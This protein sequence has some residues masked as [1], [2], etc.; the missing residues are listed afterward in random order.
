MKMSIFLTSLGS[1]KSSG[2]K[3]CGSSALEGT[4][5]ATWQLSCDTSNLSLRRMPLRLANRRS[6]LVLTPTPSGVTAPM[7]VTTMGS[8][9][10]RVMLASLL[11]VFASAAAPPILAWSIILVR[12]RHVGEAPQHAERPGKPIRRQPRLHLVLRLLP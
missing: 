11:A 1:T 3:P 9:S 12:N 6:Q 4:S 5:P 7:P 8:G 2:S 10:G